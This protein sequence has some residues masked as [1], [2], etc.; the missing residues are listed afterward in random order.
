MVVLHG[1]QVVQPLPQLLGLVPGGEEPAGDSLVMH[2]LRK[3]RR[4]S[5]RRCSPQFVVT[6]VVDVERFA[7]VRHDLL[8][9]LPLGLLLASLCLCLE[10]RNSGQSEAKPRA[11]RWIGNLKKKKKRFFGYP[12]EDAAVA[13]AHAAQRVLLLGLIL[14]LP[15]GVS[16]LLPQTLSLKKKMTWIQ[17][18]FCLLK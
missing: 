11:E 5:H 18:C 10:E 2:G 8:L 13:R 16:L 1:L 14:G 9:L 6:Q 17:Q 15:V 4:C 12:L 3:H 7:S